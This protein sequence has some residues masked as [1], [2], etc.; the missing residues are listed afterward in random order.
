[1]VASYSAA[2]GCSRQAAGYLI[3]GAAWLE[4][5]AVL[6]SLLLLVALALGAQ[7]LIATPCA[8]EPGAPAVPLEAEAAGDYDALIGDALAAFSAREL[9]RARALFERAHAL[10][11]SARTLRGLGFAAAELKD[12]TRARRELWAAL[13]HPRQP[14]TPSQRSEVSQLLSWM[15]AELGVLS[16]ETRPAQALL[17]LNGEPVSEREL[18]LEPGLYRL[19]LEAEGHVAASSE[20]HLSRAEHRQLT[21]H[22]EPAAPVAGSP[23]PAAPRAMARLR[24]PLAVGHAPSAAAASPDGELI[25]RWW[26]WPLVG[27]VVAGS[28]LGM[29]ALAHEPSAKPY[30]PNGVGGVIGVLGL[31][32]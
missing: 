28:A 18:V 11:P 20:L 27:V 25:E 13:E 6:G 9:A 30:R 32:R 16:I 3:A 12:Y 2:M 10:R 29:V 7:L 14:L 31:R 17:Q 21:L 24:A 4:R 19:R 1:M 5:R 15:R 23:A 22:L 26:F 8:A